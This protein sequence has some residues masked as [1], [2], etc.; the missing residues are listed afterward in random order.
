MTWEGRSAGA[1]WNSVRMA[2]VTATDHCTT[3][4]SLVETD[5]HFKATYSLHHQG[6]KA[7]STPET[8]V[9]MYQTKRSNIPEDMTASHSSPSEPD[10]THTPY[11]TASS[12]ACKQSRRPTDVPG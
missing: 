6:D 8:S 1:E 2:S 12:K 7:V 5:R 9:T 4:Y 3:P 11:I 10:L